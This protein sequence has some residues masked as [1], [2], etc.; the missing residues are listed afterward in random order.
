[1]RMRYHE[2]DISNIE[3]IWETKYHSPRRINIVIGSWRGMGTM[4][5]KTI[6]DVLK[7]EIK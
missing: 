5:L 2:Q 4:T 3:C 1:M 7:E 6:L